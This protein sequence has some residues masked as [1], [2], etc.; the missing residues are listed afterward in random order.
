M[1]RALFVN[2]KLDIMMIYNPNVGMWELVITKDETTPLTYKATKSEPVKIMEAESVK[3]P[4]AGAKKATAPE[5]KSST[6]STST[7]A[8]KKSTTAAVT[9]KM[10]NLKL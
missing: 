9:K 10:G 7:A 1:P 3:A 4:A 8:S 6:A 5:K 2:G